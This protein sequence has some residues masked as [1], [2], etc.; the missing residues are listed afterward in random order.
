MWIEHDGLGVWVGVSP[1]LSGR[2][3]RVAEGVHA[4]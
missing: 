1:S 4:T 2:L 3:V